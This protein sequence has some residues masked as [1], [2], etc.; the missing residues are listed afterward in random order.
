MKALPNRIVR[1]GS[2]DEVQGREKTGL[3]R[4]KGGVSEGW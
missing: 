2:P 4:R 3:R 1:H